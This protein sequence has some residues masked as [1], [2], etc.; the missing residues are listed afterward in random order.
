MDSNS[1]D[2]ENE[3]LK[4]IELRSKKEVESIEKELLQLKRT[5]ELKRANIKQIE[6]EIEIN[7]SKKQNL[8]AKIKEEMETTSSK[9]CVLIPSDTL[10]PVSSSF[11][12]SFVN[13]HHHA[14]G[15][16]TI[17]QIPSSLIDSYDS[18]LHSY[19]SSLN[20]SYGFSYDVKVL[21]VSSN[22]IAIDRSINN[23]KNPFHFQWS[24]SSTIISIESYFQND[25][26]TF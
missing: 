21:I 6:S 24:Q 25:K 15:I 13:S 17:L 14:D 16:F 8:E 1:I 19:Y 11:I 26:E 4:Q 12:Q 3:D 23:R 9:N 2:Q 5:L 20:D 22:H 7:K 18:S 10:V